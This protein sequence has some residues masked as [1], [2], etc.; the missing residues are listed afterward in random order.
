MTLVE[1]WGSPW[2]G[3]QRSFAARND[4]VKNCR[5]PDADKVIRVHRVRLAPDSVL[6]EVSIS[7]EFEL[8]DG[9]VGLSGQ[10]RQILLVRQGGSWQIASAELLF[11]G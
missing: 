11:R 4:P 6:M 2:A 10:T 3:T 1:D 7:Q 5:I 9:K 8:S